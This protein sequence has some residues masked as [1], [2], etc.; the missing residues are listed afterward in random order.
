MIL[1]GI[2]LPSSGFVQLYRLLSPPDCFAPGVRLLTAL[3][4]VAYVTHSVS[5]EILRWFLRLLISKGA[6]VG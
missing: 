4:T 1:A 2:S 6:F 5:I 3:A